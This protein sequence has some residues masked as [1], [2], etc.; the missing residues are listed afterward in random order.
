MLQTKDNNSRNISIWNYSQRI[1]LI[2][3]IGQ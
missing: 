3:D 2:S 1:R